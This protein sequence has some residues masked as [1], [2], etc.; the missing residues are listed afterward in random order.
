MVL[1]PI[2]G[3]RP[4]TTSTSYSPPSPLEHL[5]ILDLLE[6][7]GS[8][9][10]A[11]VYLAMHQSTVCRSLRLMQEQFHLD[12]RQGPAVCRHGHNACLQQLR[13][14]YREHRLM[15]GRPRVGTDPLHHSL[16]LHEP[17]LQAVPAR[18]RSSRQWA[19]LVGHGLLDGAIVSSWCHGRTVPAGE[20]PLWDGLRTLELG[21]LPLQL[22]AASSDAERVL[23]PR[24][25]AA[26]LL[27]Q[28]LENRQFILEQQSQACQEP[29]ASLKRARD[30]G[31]ALPL[32]TPLLTGRWLAQQKL[33]ALPSQAPLQQRLWLLLPQHNAS[34][35]LADRL[36]R[37][38]R[39][40]IARAPGL[41]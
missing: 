23:L 7:T 15:A 14:A 20:L 17:T 27:H 26:P 18:F 13:L 19:E 35:R 24:R 10:R 33:R 16:L 22:V 38:L 40:A 11:G 8:Q 29:D 3:A 2:P 37:Q 12:P 36:V 25:A 41:R 21:D 6:L 30:R 32:C 28:H 9:A 1:P 5:H 4:A 31:W 34:G 39:A